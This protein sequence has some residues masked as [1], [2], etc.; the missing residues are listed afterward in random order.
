MAAHDIYQVHPVHLAFVE[1]CKSMWTKVV[2][3]DFE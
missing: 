1:K 3:Y 2:I